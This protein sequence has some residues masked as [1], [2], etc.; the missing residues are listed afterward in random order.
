MFSICYHFDEVIKMQFVNRTRLMAIMAAQGMKKKELAEELSITP[1]NLTLK[2]KGTRDFK[3]S[4]I[5]VLR[6]IF[7]VNIFFL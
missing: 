7:G 6:G 3:E 1:Q 5:S 4:E 2:I